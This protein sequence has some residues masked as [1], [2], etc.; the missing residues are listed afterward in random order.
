MIYVD[1]FLLLNEDDPPITEPSSID[2]GEM[3]IDVNY[4]ITSRV[5]H[6]LNTTCHKLC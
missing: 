4:L 2:T 3:L 1:A 5:T 6:N